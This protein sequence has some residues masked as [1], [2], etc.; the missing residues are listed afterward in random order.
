MTVSTIG[1]GDWSID[2]SWSETD[3]EASMPTLRAGT[4]A[5]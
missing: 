1:F 4:D 2:V 5:A 3:G